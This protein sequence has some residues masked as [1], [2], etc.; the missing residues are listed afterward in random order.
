MDVHDSFDVIGSRIQNYVEHQDDAHARELVEQS[1]QR[2]GIMN[3]K[4]GLGELS[5]KLEETGLLP[6]YLEAEASRIDTFDSFWG[7]NNADGRLTER[8]LNAAAHDAEHFDATTR[9]AA[10]YGERN[11]GNFRHETSGFESIIDGFNI[12]NLRA[13]D[14]KRHEAG[15]VK[16]PYEAFSGSLEDNACSYAVG[17]SVRNAFSS[18]RDW[19]SGKSQPQSDGDMK[20]G[21][22]MYG[23]DG[24]QGM[25]NADFGPNRVCINGQ[26]GYKFGDREVVKNDLG[27]WQYTIRKGDT[28]NT[29]ARDILRDKNG[30]EPSE[31]EVRRLSQVFEERNGYNKG[32]R[33][34]DRIYANDT[35]LIPDQF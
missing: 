34:G 1:L 29:I 8:E 33:S 18:F 24:K 32:G 12:D 16:D 15:L 6:K 30:Y 14:A 19:L 21:E 11:Y 2:S 22:T 4:E 10:Q 5:R 3:S 17:D 9:L 31:S 26:E 28:L 7:T 23:S 35:M 13:Y 25:S 20:A 27:D